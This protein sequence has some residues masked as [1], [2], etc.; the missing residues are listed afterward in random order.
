[1]NRKILNTVKDWGILILW[2]CFVVAFIYL[3]FMV[4]KLALIH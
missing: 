1:M 2:M 3:I 4:K